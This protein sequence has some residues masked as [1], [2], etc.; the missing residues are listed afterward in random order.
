MIMTYDDYDI[1]DNGKDDDSNN[2]N[3]IGSIKD[4]NDHSDKI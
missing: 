1:Y 3:N 4:D 2:N